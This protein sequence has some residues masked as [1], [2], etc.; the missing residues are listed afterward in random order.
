MD[1]V[2]GSLLGGLIG[3]AMGAPVESWNFKD[4]EAKYA[5]VDTFE[6]NGTDDS[7]VKLIICRALI[8]HGGHIGCDE[9]AESFMANKQ[10]Y[11]LFY[12]PVRNMFHKLE[13]EL[14]LPVDAGY[15]NMQSS[16]SAMAISPMGLINACNPRQAARETF[17]VASL[18]HSGPAAFCR[19]GACIMASAVAQAMVPGTTV[20]EILEA[21]I[22]Y[23]HPVSSR[24][25]IEKIE[26]VLQLARRLGDYKAFREAYYEKYLQHVICDSRETIPATLA[27]FYLSEGDPVRSIINASNFGRDA[28][29]NA[30]MVGAIAGA[31]KGV[32]GLKKEWVAQIEA[33]GDEQKRIARQLADLIQARASEAQAVSSLIGSMQ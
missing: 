19:D 26:E 2:Y 3:D 22:K 31:F 23:L 9:L 6:G 15:G 32:G 24:L 25:M 33:G 27:I 8:K 12:I 13:D 30:S 16:S 5:L 21:S 7:A 18:V 29:T 20:D 14:C 28:D 10:Y 11:N 1:R 4:I 17:D